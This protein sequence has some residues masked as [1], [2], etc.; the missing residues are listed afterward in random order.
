MDFKNEMMDLVKKHLPLQ[1]TENLKEY[2]DECSKD[3]EKI[4]MLTEQTNALASTVNK[5]SIAIDEKSKREIEVNEKSI[6]LTI[7]EKNINERERVVLN[8]END[9]KLLET[10]LLC[11]QE[12]QMLM[13]DLCGLLFRNPRFVHRT[14]ETIPVVRDIM[15]TNYN[16][17][18]GISHQEKTGDY[19]EMHSKETTIEKEQI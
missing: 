16:N 8:R 17:G 5:L 19:V 6:F 10:K 3:K 15:S 11:E 2:L 9:Q 7:R 13:K 4:R 14:Q 18:S 12:K 1:A